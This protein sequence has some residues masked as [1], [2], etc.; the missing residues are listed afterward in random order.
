MADV[1]EDR[2]DL[3]AER[4]R[5]WALIEQTP[6]LDWQLLTKR[7]QN[8][9]AMLPEGIRSRVWLGTTAEDQR[10]LDERIQHLASV[11][12]VAVVFL[13]CEPLLSGLRLPLRRCAECRH[14]QP[15]GLVCRNCGRHTLAL[16]A[17]HWVIA[18]EES[19]H[20]ARRMDEAW[21]RDIRDQC[22]SLG[23][24]FFYK[25]RIENGRKVELPILDGRQWAEFPA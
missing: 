5:L 20:G 7:P 6:W 14:C 1:F 10:R 21:V 13:S 19:G 18:G 16:K 23:V 15:D 2:R 11:H 22:E 3:D 4:A 9:A 24:A 17:V 8:V 12:G 25:Q